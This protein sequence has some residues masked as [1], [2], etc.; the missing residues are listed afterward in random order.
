MSGSGSVQRLRGEA[1]SIS[2]SIAFRTSALSASSCKK[3]ILKFSATARLARTKAHGMMRR[4][5]SE[6][7]GLSDAP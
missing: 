2:K 1:R 5:S 4:N 3:N 7:A 6:P